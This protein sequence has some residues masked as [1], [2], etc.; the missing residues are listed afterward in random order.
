MAVRR[1]RVEFVP[2]RLLTL[3]SDDWLPFTGGAA[4]QSWSDARFEWLL[5]ILGN[6]WAA[7]MLWTLFSRRASS[8]SGAYESLAAAAGMSYSELVE[9]VKAGGLDAALRR[10]A[11]RAVLR[12]NPRRHQI[13]ILQRRVGP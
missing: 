4:L 12:R 3:D 8:V 1:G 6:C 9:A 13:E 5:S 7:W 10:A 11:E 2:P